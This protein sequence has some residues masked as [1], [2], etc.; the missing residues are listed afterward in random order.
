MRDGSCKCSAMEW[1][2][3]EWSVSDAFDVFG[4]FGVFVIVVV[5]GIHLQVQLLQ[6]LVIAIDFHFDGFSAVRLFLDS[7][8][9]HVVRSVRENGHGN[10]T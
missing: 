2:G 6:A 5:L 3:S 1:K 9:N 10:V 7:V 8:V 4:L